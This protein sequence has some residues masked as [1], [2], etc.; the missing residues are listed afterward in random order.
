MKGELETRLLNISAHDK[1]SSCRHKYFFLW[2]NE[3]R[4]IAGLV[5]VSM[6][7]I[8]CTILVVRGGVS[9]GP[10]KARSYPGGWV[11]RHQW[12][13]WA[14][15]AADPDLA[16]AAAAVLTGSLPRETPETGLYRYSIQCNGAGISTQTAAND[17]WLQIWGKN[18][19][20]CNANFNKEFEMT[21]KYH[22]DNNTYFFNNNQN[23]DDCFG[24][25]PFSS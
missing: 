1:S 23:A 5:W 17:H 25:S 15:D 20:E 24:R 16:Q 8:W 7:A 19:N 13:R 9:L 18:G 12:S 21:E 22:L 10:W 11:C 14:E 2:L 3:N 6:H 4:G